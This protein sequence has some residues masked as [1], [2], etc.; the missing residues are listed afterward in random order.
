MQGTTG[1]AFKGS[2]AFVLAVGVCLFGPASAF[3]VESYV[4]EPVLS[5][6]GDCTTSL[7]D[8]VPDPGP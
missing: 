3:A 8:E 4:F 5:L 1:S 6:T 2:L 7:L